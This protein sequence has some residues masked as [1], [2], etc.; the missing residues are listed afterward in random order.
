MR[1]FQLPGRSPIRVTEAAAATSQ[2]LATLTAI[3]TLRR[4]GN[5]IDAAVAA[6]AVLAVVEPELTGIGGDGFM[7]YAPGGGSKVIA[8]NGS[9]HSPKA[10]TTDWYLERGF[11]E[12]PMYGP[13]AVTVPGLIDA[14]ARITADHGT[15]GLD[16]LLQPAIHY[17]EEGFV[18]HDRVA[19]DWARA[20]ERL[21]RDPNAARILLPQ[22]RAPRAGERFRQPELAATLRTIA[23]KGRDGFYHGPIAEEMVSLSQQSRRPPYPR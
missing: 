11:T 13:H 18:V 3:E 4:G 20:A 8:F 12:I 7:L 14:W 19:F 5:A 16:E 6:A 23:A 10:A 21:A 9:G 1:D 15:R 2:P 22:G 17:A